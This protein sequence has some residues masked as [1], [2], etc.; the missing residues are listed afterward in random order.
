MVSA[1]GDGGDWSV[2]RIHEDDP[3]KQGSADDLAA[4][5]DAADAWAREHATE[6]DWQLPA[7]PPPPLTEAP[8][9]ASVD[10]LMEQVRAVAV[11]GGRKMI[12]CDEDRLRALLGELVR[13]RGGAR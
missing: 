6:L 4:A 11:D 5:R 2:Y 8:T 7:P 3:R 13:R 10:G 12:L 1:A 9:P